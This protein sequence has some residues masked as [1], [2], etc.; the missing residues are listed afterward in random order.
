[1]YV[2]V[3]LCLRKNVTFLLVDMVQAYMMAGTKQKLQKG[4]NS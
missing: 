3:A 4:L 2:T 1:M